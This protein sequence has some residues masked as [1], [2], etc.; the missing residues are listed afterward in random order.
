MKK[1]F[2]E[3][4]EYQKQYFHDIAALLVDE[5]VLSYTIQG[6]QTA[7]AEI[8]EHKDKFERA[9]GHDSRFYCNVGN[10]AK[11]YK[12]IGWLNHH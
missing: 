6:I 9:V 7:M 8:V 10:C 2:A 3:N 1:R 4:K 5:Y 11:P 12:T